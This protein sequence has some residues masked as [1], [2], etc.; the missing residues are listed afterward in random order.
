V[1]TLTEG[2]W[3]PRVVA[4]V[5]ALVWQGLIIAALISGVRPG[6]PLIWK[7]DAHSA[8]PLPQQSVVQEVAIL[9]SMSTN[10]EPTPPLS[11]PAVVRDSAVRALGLAVSQAEEALVAGTDLNVAAPPMPAVTGDLPIRCEVHIHQNSR[12]QVQAIDFGVCTGDQVWQRSLLD[13]LQQAAG[14]VHPK[15]GASRAPV[16][17]IV[18]GSDSIS[19][20]ILATQLMEPAP[21]TAEKHDPSTQA[22]P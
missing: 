5:T 20:E 2:R 13:R 6:A 8:V 21:L 14:L 15:E 3:Q 19:P 11:G 12:G 1:R 22:A 9:P 4:C 17:T 7:P 16:K 10:A 18:F